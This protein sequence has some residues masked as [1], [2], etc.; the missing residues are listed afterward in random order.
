MISQARKDS[1][2]KNSNLLKLKETARRKKKKKR[3]STSRVTKRNKG[4]CFDLVDEKASDG[5]DIATVKGGSTSRNNQL[6]H[7]EYAGRRASGYPDENINLQIASL[8]NLLK[9]ASN[10]MNETNDSLGQMMPSN[11]NQTI[12]IDNLESE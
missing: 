9:H 6:S 5:E 10:F 4:L 8:P 7:R 3:P 1:P 2:S 12:N 11:K